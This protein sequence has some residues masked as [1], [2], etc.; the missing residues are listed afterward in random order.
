MAANSFTSFV[1]QRPGIASAAAIVLGTALIFT[2]NS[3]SNND[4]IAH[5]IKTA[6]GRGRLHQTS[7]GSQVGSGNLL[8][9]DQK[10]GSGKI[11]V[12]GTDGGKLCIQD[13]DGGGYTRFDCLNGTC[14]A[15]IATGGECP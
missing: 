13:T 2:I 12:D 10:T 14:T 7:S 9:A 15:A 4:T 1:R 6:D 11:A 5:Q 3:A 8:V